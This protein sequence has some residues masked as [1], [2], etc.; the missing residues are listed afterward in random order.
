MT[1]VL[2]S[3]SCVVWDEKQLQPLRSV[4]WRH[5][6]HLGFASQRL[7]QQHRVTTCEVR[8]RPRVQHQLNSN[9]WTVRSSISCKSSA[10]SSNG[11]SSTAC[12]AE[13]SR[14]LQLEAEVASLRRLLASQG[15]LIASIQGTVQQQHLDQ[16]QGLQAGG[17]ML[18]PAAPKAPLSPF[19]AQRIGIG[20]RR[21]RGGFD[22]RFHSTAP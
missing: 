3:S 14:L 21:L 4:S 20:D 16:Q 1:R 15:E 17:S 13:A 5:E 19:D 7:Q 22:A 18:P 8:C 11:G 12:S 9:A 10:N 2:R 6:M